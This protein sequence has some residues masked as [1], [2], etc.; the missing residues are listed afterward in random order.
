[1]ILALLGILM[2]LVLSYLIKFQNVLGR[3]TSHTTETHH[4]HVVVKKDAPYETMEDILALPFGANTSIDEEAITITKDIIKEDTSAEIHI[5]R[6]DD[7]DQ[8]YEAFNQDAPEVLLIKD[9]HLDLMSLVSET[10]EDEIKIIKTYTYEQE[11]DENDSVNTSTDTF[12]IY[13][14]GLDFD[15]DIEKTQ[16]SDANIILTV[17]PVKKQ[18][19]MT[20]IPRDTFV[21]RHTNGQKDKLSLVGYS[22]IKETMKTIEDF[23]ENDIDYSLKVNWT[24][25]ID[26]VDAVGGIEINSPYSFKSQG[27]YFEAG[28]NYLDGQKAL[29]FVSHRQTLP[30]GED[31]RAQ[32]QQNVLEAI[33]KQVMSPSIITNYHGFLDAV[34]DSIILSMPEKQLNNLIKDQIN[35]MSSWDILKTQIIGDVFDTYDAYSAKGKYQVVKEPQEHLLKQAQDLI[36]KMEDNIEISQDMIE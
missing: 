30:D 3:I 20:S 25:V 9:A 8:L 7:F 26:V 31:S 35:T 12:S 10:F 21:V 15:G 27:V 4:V 17:N 33:I 1:I 29:S 6:Y 22:G 5:Q 19:L 13:I 23:L 2:V 28:Y 14:S 24:S 34:G 36:Q 32:N 11:L 18:I 16:R